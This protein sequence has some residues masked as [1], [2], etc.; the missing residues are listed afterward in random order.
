[1]NRKR[2][3]LMKGAVATGVVG[4]AVSTGL[5]AP[6][7]ALAEWPE[8]V[9]KTKSFEDALKGVVGSGPPAGSGEI[10]LKAPEVAENGAVVPI[11]V[12]TTLP[13]VTS[14][15]IFAERNTFPYVSTFYF[16]EG[17]EPFVKTRIKMAETAKVM[18]V[19][20]AGGKYYSAQQEVKVTVG[21]CE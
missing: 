4:A 15:S 14:I 20:E 21:G 12:S 16:P 5:F 13:G 9:F 8:T 6:R 2:R 19:A 10:K 11:E 17:T 18:A 3:I 7:T 1:M